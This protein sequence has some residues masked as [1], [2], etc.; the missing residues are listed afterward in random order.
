MDSSNIVEVLKNRIV[1]DIINDNEIVKAIDSPYK[2]NKEWS[3]L[4]LYDNLATSETVFSP[5]IYTYKRFPDTIEDTITF[6]LVLV[7]IP[8][9]Y[10]ANKIWVQPN[11]EI[12]IFSHY[13]HMRVNNKL[14]KANRNDYIARLLKQKFNKK[15]NN[16]AYD[17]KL[18]ADTENAYSDKF[19]YRKLEFKCISLNQSLCEE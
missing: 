7:N 15:N 5:H 4:F 6:I 9:T 10:D 8:R 12:W 2:N 3:P 17:F 16:I 19:L 18:E 1:K 14:V 13:N 11:V